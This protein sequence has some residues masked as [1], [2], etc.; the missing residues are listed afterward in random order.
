[1]V[2]RLKSDLVDANGT[3][4]WVGGSMG[5]KYVML[6]PG[7]FLMGEG[8][9]GEVR[10]EV[11]SDDPPHARQRQPRNAG[12]AAAFVLDP[13]LPDLRRAADMQRAGGAGDGPDHGGVP[14]SVAV[15]GAAG[16]LP[17]HDRAPDRS[18]RDVIVLIPT[19]G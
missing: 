9:R 17:G 1:M 11:V 5:A 15:M 4:E 3:V 8:A 14:R 19:S 13:D 6:Y 12:E 7:S 16:V 2:R 18:F 10:R